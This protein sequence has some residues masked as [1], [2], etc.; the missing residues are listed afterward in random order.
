MNTTITALEAPL[1]IKTP[2]LLIMASSQSALSSKLVNADVLYSK[3]SYLPNTY[4][5]F[6]RINYVIITEHQHLGEACMRMKVD[7][8]SRIA[9][10]RKYDQEL[11]ETKNQDD[12]NDIQAERAYT[13]KNATAIASAESARLAS[14]LNGMKEAA[15]RQQT[16]EFQTSLEQD[17]I[18]TNTGI[19]DAKTRLAAIQEERRVLT[20]AIDAIESKGFASIAKDT[21]LT[22]EKVIALGVQ[23]PQIA[24]ITLAIEQMKATLE[25]G[26]EGINFIAMVKRRD[27]MRERI[28]KLFEQVTQRE[29]EK[30]ALT[31]RIELIECFH[32]MD[33]QRTLYVEQYQK[34]AQTIDSFLTINQAAALD[35]KAFARRFISSGLQLSSYLQPIR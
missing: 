14:A 33:D 19:D 24:V 34:I 15:N 29:K 3:T 9:Q 8:E 4:E 21:L 25:S 26:A 22:A 18:K 31:Q 16:Q 10:L 11:G 2:D 30:L 20:E 12:I 1:N 13:L 32:A 5:R 7:I 6:K 17:V 27:G 23:P 35:E 28:D